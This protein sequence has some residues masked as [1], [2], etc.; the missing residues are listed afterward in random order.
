MLRRPEWIRDA[1][2]LEDG[3]MLQVLG[4]ENVGASDSSSGHDHGVVHGDPELLGECCEQ[5]DR[6]RAAHPC[7]PRKK[8]AP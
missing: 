1:E 4:S 2:T 8:A 7:E 6:F 5:C 3:A